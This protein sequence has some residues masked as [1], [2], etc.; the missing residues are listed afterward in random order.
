[1]AHATAGDLAGIKPEPR[2]G[3]VSFRLRGYSPSDPLSPWER[4]GVRV[5]EDAPPWMSKDRRRKNR[6]GSLTRPS[7]DL[8]LRE[9]CRSGAPGVCPTNQIQPLSLW[10][11][12]AEGRV[13][14]QA[15]FAL[16]R[17]E[18]QRGVHGQA[19][20]VAADDADLGVG[21]L[22]LGLD[23]VAAELAGTFGEVEHSF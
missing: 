19:A 21:N 6:R 22:A 11:R 16:R 15:R 14:A 12:V 7:A 4:A 2:P 18:N 17:P 23:L 1:M 8:S 13:R 9:R 5:A 20:A 3:P 10:E